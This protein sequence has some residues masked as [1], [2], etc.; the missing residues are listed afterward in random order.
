MP[1]QSELRR[2]AVETLNRLIDRKRND[3]DWEKWPDGTS[4]DARR[5]VYREILEGFDTI[6]EVREYVGGMPEGNVIFTARGD[7]ISFLLI[8]LIIADI[9][10]NPWLSPSRRPKAEKG[11]QPSLLPLIIRCAWCGKYLGEK[12]PYED[13]SETHGIC[14]ECR[15]KYFPK[16]DS[17][18]P[19][20]IPRD[21]LKRIAE[22]YGWWAARQ[23]EALCPRNDVT[24]VEREAKRLSEV[25]KHRTG[26]KTW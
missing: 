6:A 22:K 2:Q 26:G 19:L 14:P 13:K 10:K 20:T 8:K 7:E 3:P 16:K 18:S 4:S 5:A 25:V 17:S 15:A 1:N 24:C 11:R 12:E 23:A 9:E 21:D